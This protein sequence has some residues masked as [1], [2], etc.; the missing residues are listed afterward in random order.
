VPSEPTIFVDRSF[1]RHE[2]ASRLRK[3]GQTVEVHDDHFAID[4]TDEEWL[5][6]IGIR[7]W[8]CLT[9]DIKIGRNALQRL[10]VAKH[11]VKLFVFM[12]GNMTGQEMGESVANALG[13]IWRT[14]NREKPPFIAKVYAAGQVRL[15]KD[16][17][18]LADELRRE[19]RQ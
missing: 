7:G 16:R 9:K 8:L 4:A 17:E 6:E 14:A 12:S 2:V 10:W 5:A 3:T 1:G 13:R 18:E 15:W 11:G 19:L